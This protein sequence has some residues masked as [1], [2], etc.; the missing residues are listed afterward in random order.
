MD[1][2]IMFVAPHMI[3]VI[4]QLL[5]AG[6]HR[7]DDFHGK[8]LYGEDRIKV[9]GDIGKIPAAVVRLHTTLSKSGKRRCKLVPA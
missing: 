6:V 5:P 1:Y 8:G 9:S 2:A 3:P 7:H 4:D